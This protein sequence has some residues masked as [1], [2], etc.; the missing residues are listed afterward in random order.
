M[1]HITPHILLSHFLLLDSYKIYSK[2]GFM[3]NEKNQ[4]KKKMFS[5]H[6]VS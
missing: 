2:S 4:F 3:K 1:E 5:I 6:N